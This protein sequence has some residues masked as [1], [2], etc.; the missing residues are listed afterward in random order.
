MPAS[1]EPRDHVTVVSQS[2]QFWTFIF[3]NE[4]KHV[5]NNQDF[6]SVGILDLGP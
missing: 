2:G 4:R 6:S 1:I 5:Q 3:P